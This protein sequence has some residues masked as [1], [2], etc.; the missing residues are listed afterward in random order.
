MNYCVADIYSTVAKCSGSAKVSDPSDRIFLTLSLDYY[1][2]T[3]WQPPYSSYQQFL[4][5]TIDQMHKDG[6]SYISMDE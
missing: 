4:Y 6:N 2:A 1:S 3:L 5:D